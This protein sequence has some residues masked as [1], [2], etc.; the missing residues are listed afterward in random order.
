MSIINELVETGKL[1]DE[2]VERIGRN[3]SEFIKEAQANPE[4]F[5]QAMEKLSAI[6]PKM[7]K[8][9]LIYTGALSAMGLAARAGEGLINRGFG[10]ISDAINKSRSYKAMMDDNPQL[11]EMDSESVQKS[12]DTLYRFNPH[13]AKDPMVA[14]QYVSQAVSMEGAPIKSINELVSSRKQ[15]AETR[16]SESLLPE[17]AR[18]IP[19]VKP[20]AVFPGGPADHTEKP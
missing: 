9:M 3:T 15:I 19:G 2:Q 6:D 5:E 7:L 1:T 8:D 16:K 14:G 10:A 12:F 11:G 4:L 18:A 17:P 13:Y 20:A